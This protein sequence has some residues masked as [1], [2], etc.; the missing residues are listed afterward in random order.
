MPARLTRSAAL[1]ERTG[2]PELGAVAA[3]LER[4]RR[5][6]S[7]LAEQLHAQAATL[8][9][10]GAAADRRASS[11]AAPKIQLVVAMVLVPSALLAI[12]A[13]LVAYS[14]SLFRAF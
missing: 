3:A 1:R 9:S 7:P 12:A 11:K 5:F 6:G 8:R 2:A 14:G 4:S 13:A 10:P